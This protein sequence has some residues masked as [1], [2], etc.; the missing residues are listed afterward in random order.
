MPTESKKKVRKPTKSLHKGTLVSDIEYISL[1]SLA[2]Y[3][4][5]PRVGNVEAVAESLEQNGQFKPI[6]VNRGDK[7]GRTTEILAGNHTWLAARHLGWDTIAAV[8]VDV[9]DETAARIVLADNR[10]SDMGEYDEELLADL[11]QDL[12]DLA[13][14]AYTDID[15]GE[16]LTTLPDNVEVVDTYAGTKKHKKMAD[17]PDDIKESEG[18]V[19]GEDIED[20]VDEEH[21]AY[22]PSAVK[23]KEKKDEEVEAN[24]IDAQPESL[25]GMIQVADPNV[26]FE[27]EK[28]PYDI[29][30]LLPG[31]IPELPETI[32][33]WAGPAIAEDDGEKWWLYNYSSDSTKGLPWERTFLAFYVFEDRYENWWATP[34]KMV[35]R[36]MNTGCSYAV[37]HDFS[38]IHSNPRVEQMYQAYRCFWLAR[39]MQE[40]GIFVV[41]NLKIPPAVDDL[42]WAIAGIPDRPASLALQL[43]TVVAGK[44]TDKSQVKRALSVIKEAIDVIEPRS[45]LVYASEAGETA[46]DI[47][48]P[49]CRTVIVPT[50]RRRWQQSKGDWLGKEM[51][52]ERE[53][54]K[55]KERKVKVRK[56][57]RVTDEHEQKV[58][59]DRAKKRTS[60]K[61]LKR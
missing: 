50:R 59:E 12:P 26:R 40:C 14:T 20:G 52:R 2:P 35:T 44:G 24:S 27:I 13:G 55:G 8:F 31:L 48:Q 39:F 58:S 54:S 33:C 18:P 46:L 56:P 29:P 36:M 49:S 4:R 38:V 7:T 21:E 51:E 3:H 23:V 30:R 16:I 53:L 41:P 42:E 10:T 60:S 5:N 11:L 32:D 37:M 25:P 28:T 22:R 15:L 6:V 34:D 57:T 1:D 47:I 45:L 9:D 43:Q 17:N 19:D 61:R